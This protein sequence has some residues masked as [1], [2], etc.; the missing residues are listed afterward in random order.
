LPFERIRLLSLYQSYLSIQSINK[1]RLRV[2]FRIGSIKS[3]QLYHVGTRQIRLLQRRRPR[4]RSTIKIIIQQLHFPNCQQIS[5]ITHT[6]TTIQLLTI[7]YNNYTNNYKF[8][9]LSNRYPA[10]WLKLETKNKIHNKLFRQTLP[11]RSVLSIDF[12]NGDKL[13]ANCFV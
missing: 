9:Q 2:I 10:Y 7:R 4:P 11:M 1:N 12:G 5:S 3:N 8:P 13:I 6:I